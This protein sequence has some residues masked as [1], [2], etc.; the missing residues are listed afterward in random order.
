MATAGVRVDKAPVG[1]GLLAGL[2]VAVCCGG[3]PLFAS[4]G[5]GAGFAGLRLWRWVWLL[6]A[7]GTVLIVAVNWTYYRKTAGGAT[8]R[9]ATYAAPWS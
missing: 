7:L 3:L 6:L 9:V 4:I 1:G 5:L 2:V 8:R